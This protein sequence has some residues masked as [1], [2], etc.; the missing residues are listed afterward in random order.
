MRR[1]LKELLGYSIKA[2]DGHHGDINDFLFDGN[3]WII[4]Y[5]HADLGTIFKD[6]KVI[7]PRMF[8]K[9]PSWINQNFEVSLS[10]KDIENGPLIDEYL[11]V[12]KQYEKELLK[13]FD[14]QS[15]IM[16]FQSQSV[17]Q[18]A[19]NIHLENA[20]TKSVSEDYEN[21][22]SLRSFRE[23]CN[24]SIRTKDGFK[25]KLNDLII[26]DSNWEVKYIIIDLNGSIPWSRKVLI[27][28]NWIERI[29]YPKKSIK[30]NLN[31]DSL[32]NSKDFN[33]NEL[34]NTKKVTKRFDYLG[35]PKELK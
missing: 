18:T 33:P 13:H 17:L 11:P 27:N 7:I 6:K 14:L 21:K 15:H 1:S 22:G 23:V 26:D 34:V 19:G 32:L 8:W 12:S 28:V 5:I 30:I 29:S 4:N 25:G 10:I 16:R 3:N 20:F 2:T 31:S 35:R 24:Y 9:N